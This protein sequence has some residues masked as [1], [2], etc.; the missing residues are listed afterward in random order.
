MTGTVIFVGMFLGVLGGAAL[1]VKMVLNS[2]ESKKNWMAHSVDAVDVPVADE[3]DGAPAP[4]PKQ[5]LVKYMDGL[6]RMVAPFEKMGATL[7]KSQHET[8]LA[9]LTSLKSRLEGDAHKQD[10]EVQNM[11]VEAERSLARYAPKG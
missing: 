9:Q 6:R 4:D 10:S 3:A 2:A 7:D 8:K 5:A 11:L 1:A